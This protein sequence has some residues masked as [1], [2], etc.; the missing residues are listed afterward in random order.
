MHS[1][2]APCRPVSPEMI[3]GHD[4]D[5][6]LVLPDFLAYSLVI[7]E[8]IKDDSRRG[9]VP[10]SPVWLTLNAKSIVLDKRLKSGLISSLS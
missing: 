7:C 8:Q 9:Q 2:G 5:G 10:L 4:I 3:S 1:C 6:I